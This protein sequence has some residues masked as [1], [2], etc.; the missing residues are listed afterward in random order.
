MV[1]IPRLAVLELYRQHYCYVVRRTAAESVDRAYW[2]LIETLPILSDPQNVQV[3]SGL[4]VGDR[5]VTT[6]LQHVTHECVVRVV[7]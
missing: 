4:E 1:T 6:G 5:V 3:I 2:T 7:E